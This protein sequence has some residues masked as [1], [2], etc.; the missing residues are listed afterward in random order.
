MSNLESAVRQRLVAYCQEL[1]GLEERLACSAGDQQASSKLRAELEAVKE[2]RTQYML[3]AAPYIREYFQGDKPPAQPLPSLAPSNNGQFT[4][5]LEQGQGHRKG[6]VF[7]RYMSNIE[8]HTKYTEAPEPPRQYD[9]CNDCEG[10]PCLVIDRDFLVC[11]NCGRCYP[12]SNLSYENLSFEQQISDV[13]PLAC[14]RRSNHFAEWLSKLQAREATRIPDEVMTAVKLELKKQRLTEPKQITQA[15][16]KDIL[17][18]LKFSKFYEHVPSI[19]SIITKTSAPKFPGALEEKLKL[20]FDE[21]QEPFERFKGAKRSNMLSYSFLLYKFCE[22][23]GEDEYLPYL[24][25]LK[26][27]AKLYD[28][29]QVWKKI[30]ADRMWE[31]IPTV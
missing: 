8:H 30:C 7:R 17:K 25:L 2:A 31:Y 15:R 10:A 3:D 18:K 20:L 28:C 22:L 13:V 9:G 29:D 19:H 6:A 11:P 5:L 23:L 4:W 12:S 26:S 27:S 1:S 16:I 24:P 14:Y 21:I